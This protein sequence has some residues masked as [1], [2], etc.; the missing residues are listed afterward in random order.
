MALAHAAAALLQAKS[1]ICRIGQINE[2][3]ILIL[4]AHN[5]IDWIIAARTEA[6]SIPILAGSAA[7]NA[8]LH[9]VETAMR[10]ANIAESL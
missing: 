6:K 4:L 9:E 8:Q 10:K 1:R 7:T 3:K 2:A 5:I